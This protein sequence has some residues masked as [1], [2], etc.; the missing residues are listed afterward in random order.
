MPDLIRNESRYINNVKKIL[1]PGGKFLITTD[2]KQAP[3]ISIALQKAGFKVTT[4][5]LKPQ[6]IQAKGSKWAK[7][8]ITEGRQVIRII[9]QKPK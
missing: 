3:G 1:I 2:S 7:N 9:A 6:E 5:E 8:E 4:R